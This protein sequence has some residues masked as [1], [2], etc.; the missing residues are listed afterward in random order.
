MALNIRNL[1]IRCLFDDI[2]KSQIS[3][4]FSRLS[5]SSIEFL[6]EKLTKYDSPYIYETILSKNAS[7]KNLKR[8]SVLIPISFKEETDSCGKIVTKT[9]FTLSKRTDKMSS[10]KGDVSFLGNRIHINQYLSESL[11][12]VKTLRPHSN[13]Y[14]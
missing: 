14:S 2:K 5:S 8:A 13:P 1:T 10:F 11:S 12:I 3:K 4:N 9:F 7:V 6:K